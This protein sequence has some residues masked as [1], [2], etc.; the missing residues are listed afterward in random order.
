MWCPG[1]R[2]EYRDG[3]GRCP[4]CGIVLVWDRPAA[5]PR[6]PRRLLPAAALGGIAGV[7]AVFAARAAATLLWSVG[8]PPDALVAGLLMVLSA[9]GYAA[10]AFFFARYLREVAWPRGARLRVVAAL[11]A[12]SAALAAASVAI[13]LAAWAGLDPAMTLARVPTFPLLSVLM[14]ASAVAF[15]AVERR[16]APARGLPAVGRASGWAMLAC[17]ASLAIHMAAAVWW[18]TGVA[19]TT[20]HGVV[21]PGRWVA[22]PVAAGVA[23]SVVGYLVAVIRSLPR[24]EPRERAPSAPQIRA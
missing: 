17:I 4:T 14:S 16:D 20:R 7:G 2:G 22:L 10:L 11:A 23:A 13:D 6:K 8:D 12:V 1:C 21:V 9:S 3:I 15:F 24:D 18:L 5:P 19:P